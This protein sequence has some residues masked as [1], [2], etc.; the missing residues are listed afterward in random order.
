MVGVLV[1]MKNCRILTFSFKKL[2]NI[3]NIN[4]VLQEKNF[5]SNMS[6]F[7]NLLTS[8]CE[9]KNKRKCEIKYN[10]V[11]IWIKNK[12]SLRVPQ[13]VISPSLL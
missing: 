6:Y 4:K 12:T 3:G 13:S 10:Y 9:T 8:L 1:I 5:I 11:Y 2:I 7:I